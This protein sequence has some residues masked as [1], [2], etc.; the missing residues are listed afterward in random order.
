MREYLRLIGHSYADRHQF[1]QG[2]NWRLRTIRT[3]LAE[4]G[5]NE[6]VL[7]HG[8]QREVFLSSF[9]NNSLGILKSGV[10]KPDL[11]GLQTVAEISELARERW[12]EPRATRRDDYRA[13]QRSGI[14]DLIYGSAII[15]DQR[16]AT[17]ERRLQ[18]VGDAD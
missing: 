16:D 6:A 2:P 8:I 5:I 15:A 10:G 11:S 4:L 1:G 14:A 9:C 18:G 12:M 17:S 7:R 13:W 3:A